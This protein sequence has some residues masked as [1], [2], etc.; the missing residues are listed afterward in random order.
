MF[1]DE[2]II[3]A[4][5]GDGGDGITAFRREKYVP[6]GGPDGGNGGRGS[7]IVFVAD[8]NMKTLIHLKNMRH[9]KGIPGVSGGSKNQA[10]ANAEAFYVK[11]PIGTIVTDNETNL[12]IADLSHEG[13][14]AVVCRGGAGGRGNKAFKTHGNTAPEVSEFGE[15]GEEKVLKVELKLLA[16]VGL[17]GLPSVG[18]ST[19]LSK[20]TKAKPKIAAYHFTTLTPN[21][22]VC[23][24]NN[25]RSFVVA[26]LPG[27]IEGAALGAGLGD[28]FLKHIERTRVIAHIIDMSG[29]EGRNP[30]DDF[31]LILNELET[32]NLKLVQKKQIVIANKMDIETSKE[33]LILFKN[34]YKDIDVY[35]ISAEQSI[36]LDIMLNAMADIVYSTD[37]VK[38]VEDEQ[39]ESHVLYKFKKEEGYRIVKEEANVWIIKG[40]EIE[41]FFKRTK[42]T[43]EESARRFAYKL[44]KMGI[45]DELEKA[46][47]VNGDTVKILNYEFTFEA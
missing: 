24:T 46:G 23:T 5:A 43:S 41:N 37:E 6:L 12:V 45:D 4:K 39:M 20:I 26:D 40:T 21:L 25:D 9:I 10:G 16:D 22:G 3:K 47:A 29:S 11:V 8:H 14:T 32:Y 30:I 36:G 2:V 27:L 19:L 31:K 13:D 33:N 42:F 1:I 44:R 38:V 15:D 28:E 7:D 18:K 17:V 34:E 35:E